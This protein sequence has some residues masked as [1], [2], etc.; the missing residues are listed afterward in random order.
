MS[1]AKQTSD[2]C[3]CSFLRTTVNCRILSVCCCVEKQQGYLWV[4]KNRLNSSEASAECIP[5]ISLFYEECCWLGLQRKERQP[6]M[7]GN[8]FTSCF[9]WSHCSG[10]YYSEPLGHF[11]QSNSVVSR[12]LLPALS[13]NWLS[14]SKATAKT[15]GKH[16]V[17]VLQRRVGRS[18]GGQQ[19]LIREGRI[20][21]AAKCHSHSLLAE[22][23]CWGDCRSS[24]KDPPQ[25]REQVGG[26]KL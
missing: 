2:A 26:P 6:W 19:Q 23:A 25:G 15:F 21:A 18:G 11:T 7:A 1:H 12:S 16:W 14:S 20:A 4:H 8:V 5:K 13:W 9:S 17:P 3:I 22:G 24:E 10:K